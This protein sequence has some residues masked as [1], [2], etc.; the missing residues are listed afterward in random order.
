M[1]VAI[2]MYETRH[3]IVAFQL[4]WI[5]LLLFWT[6]FTL[7][8]SLYLVFYCFSTSLR[9]RCAEMYA[10]G[11]FSSFTRVYI[12]VY[13][14]LCKTMEYCIFIFN[15]VKHLSQFISIIFSPNST[16]HSKLHV[17]F[18][19]PRCVGRC[20]IWRRFESFRIMYL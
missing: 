13:F 3:V 2:C 4:N 17:A 14:P 18:P 1:Y 8:F 19:S 20:V 16:S 7:L 12:N 11:P 5:N 9:S 10:F 6:N 15:C